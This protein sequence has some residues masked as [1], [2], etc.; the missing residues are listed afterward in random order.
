M[1]TTL[2]HDRTLRMTLTGLFT[3]MVIVLSMSTFSIPVPGGHLYF[4][5]A[6]INIAAMLLDPL[7]AFIVGGVGSFLG[8]LLF[9]PAAMF[10]SLVAHGLQAVTVSLISRRSERHPALASGAG[11]TAGSL[12]M[13]VLYSLGRAYVYATPA[14]AI[15]KLPFEFLQ[16][17]IGAVAAM[18]LCYPL[19]LKQLYRQIVKKI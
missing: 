19:H 10:V 5:D 17:G 14:Y 3:G 6:I 15:V 12:V 8:D 18:V 11:V 1:H 16:A 13:V 7:S 2:S 4:C 9:Y